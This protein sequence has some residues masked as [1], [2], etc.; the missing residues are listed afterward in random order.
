MTKSA[1]AALQRPAA[2]T[3]A[4]GPP[5][6]SFFTVNREAFERWVQGMMEISQEIAQFT[7]TRLQEDAAAWAKLASCRT[8]NEAFECQQH[9]LERAAGQYLAESNRLSQMI[10]GLASAGTPS[11]QHASTPS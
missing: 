4:L 7:Q 8:P 10:V 6:D 9:F 2:A 5:L 11:A 1:R 3:T